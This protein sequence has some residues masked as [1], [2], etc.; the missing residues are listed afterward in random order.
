[1]VSSGS[2]SFSLSNAD[3]V[4]GAFDR[5]GVRRTSLLTEHLVSGYRQANLALVKLSNLQPN[6]WT[7]ETQEV[8]L[9][10][11]TATYTLEA[12]TI[13]VLI[14]T[15]R[16]G[17]GTTQND[18]VLGPLSAIEYQSIPNKSQQGVPSVYWFNRQII[19]QITLWYVPDNSSTYTLRLQT[20]R[21]VQD[22][23]LPGGETP[24]LPYR[25]LDWFEA[26]V[27]LRLAR[28][29]KPELEQARKQDAAEALQIAATQDVENVAMAI[30]PGLSG[31]YR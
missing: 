18:R 29:W 20:V 27:A 31:Y 30:V 1:M 5:I 25:W 7:E 4:T 6:L 23:N 3:I 8:A 17:T 10:E 13:M 26:E 15:N 12:R 11:G 28:I 21:Q 14:A 16:T 24:D 9:V 19:P 2:Y 22:A